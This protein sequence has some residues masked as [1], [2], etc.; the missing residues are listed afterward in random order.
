MVDAADDRLITWHSKACPREGGD[1][2]VAVRAYNGEVFSIRRLSFT[3][4]IDQKI[5]NSDIVTELT[6][7]GA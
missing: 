6:K 3:R 2:L 1:L 4:Y 5:G 7:H